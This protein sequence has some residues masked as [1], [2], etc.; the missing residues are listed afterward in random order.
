MPFPKPVECSSS[1]N[2][3]CLSESV[4][5]SEVVKWAQT[6]NLLLKVMSP[7]LQPA[8]PNGFVNLWPQHVWLKFVLLNCNIMN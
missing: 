2:F 6:L 8:C 5:Y 7:H 4:N 3:Q 1:K